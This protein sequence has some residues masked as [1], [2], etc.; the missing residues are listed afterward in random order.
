MNL[1]TDIYACFY[2]IIK[3]LAFNSSAKYL[4]VLDYYTRSVDCFT[5][6]FSKNALDS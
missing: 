3:K 2:I 6:K 4:Y 5:L 1:P